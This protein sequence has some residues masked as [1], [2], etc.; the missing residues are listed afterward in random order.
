VRFVPHTENPVDSF[1]VIAGLIDALLSENNMAY[2]DS[3]SIGLAVPA[4]SITIDAGW[5]D[6]YNLGYHDFPLGDLVMDGIGM[7]VYV[8]NDAN[9]AALAEYY[10]GR[11]ADIPPA[12]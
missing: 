5:I 3:A 9:A 11:S 6:A 4:A 7:P 1:D 10:C 8:E 2:K 12:F